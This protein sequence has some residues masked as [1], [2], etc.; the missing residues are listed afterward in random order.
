MAL[1]ETVFVLGSLGGLVAG[2][3][4]SV[5][6]VGGALIG[7]V[8]APSGSRARG[9][10]QGARGGA[11][12]V[13]GSALLFGL[14]QAGDDLRF[15]HQRLGMVGLW[16]AEL[17]ATHSERHFNG[18][19]F[20]RVRSRLPTRVC[21][22]VRAD[23]AV[24]ADRPAW[25]PPAARSLLI[26]ERHTWVATPLAPD[27]VLGMEGMH[28]GGG[29]DQDARLERLLAEPGAM[30]AWRARR[31]S[32]DRG[33]HVTNLELMVLELAPCELWWVASDT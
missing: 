5:I 16:P 22:A 8:R 23:A 33:S 31:M 24:L 25:P 12:M 14:L 28:L 4:G 18:D 6:A 10:V 15:H 20:S 3:V 27:L 26:D 9:T 11:L 19:G 2:A 7:C 32:T 13:G 29:A 30:A 1:W 17:D 21:D